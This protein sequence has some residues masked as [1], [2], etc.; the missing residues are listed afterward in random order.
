MKV[1]EPKK[2]IEK[3][4]GISREFSDEMHMIWEAVTGVD[5]GSSDEHVDKETCAVGFYKKKF[6]QPAK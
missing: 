2:E 5:G 1:S 6:I 4:R 3:K